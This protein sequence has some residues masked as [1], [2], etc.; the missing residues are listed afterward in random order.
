MESKVDQALTCFSEG[1]NCAQATFA[2]YADE[3]GMDA[4]TAMKIA[5]M[6]GGGLGLTGGVCGAVT[7]GL[8]ALGVAR[9]SAGN[10]KADKG[11][12]YALAREFLDRFGQANG[13]HICKEL[14][15]CDLGT[16]EGLAEAGARDFHANVCPTFVRSA[17]AI[18]E[19]MIAD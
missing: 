4:A 8:M 16:P 14:L 12:N 7:G 9:G 19:D 6:F 3:A 15:D 5:S 17:I 2:P 13:S 11:A 1:L 10:A 18:I